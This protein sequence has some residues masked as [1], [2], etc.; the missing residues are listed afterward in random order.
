MNPA[1]H[2]SFSLGHMPRSAD[3]KTVPETVQLTPRSTAVE[4]VPEMVHKRCSA[5]LHPRV[6]FFLGGRP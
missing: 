1:V 3:V 5:P 2:C 4:T 6:V